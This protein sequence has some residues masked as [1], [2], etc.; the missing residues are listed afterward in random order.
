[1]RKIV[2][3]FTCL[4]ML[5]SLGASLAGALSYGHERYQRFTTA[6]GEIVEIAAS[7][8]YRYSLRALVTGGTSWDVVWLGVAIPVL[9]VAFALYLRRSARGTVLFVGSLASFLYKYLLWTFDWAFNP[10]FLVY[11]AVFSLSLWTVVFV[12]VGVDGPRMR[13]VISERFPARTAAGFSFAAAGECWREGSAHGHVQTDRWSRRSDD[14]R[15]DHL[16]IPVGATASLRRP[17]SAGRISFW[18]ADVRSGP[19]DRARP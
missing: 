18:R 4:I 14:R 2:V 17:D 3:I 13:D 1:M 9:L 10:L 6:R 12:L 8:I 5:L 15:D 11:V 7:G 19:C 16:R